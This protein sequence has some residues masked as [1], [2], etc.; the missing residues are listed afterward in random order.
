M[1]QAASRGSR[2]LATLVADHPTLKPS[3]VAKGISDIFL[4]ATLKLQSG[5][6]F[7]ATSFG[8]PLVNSP[9]SGEVVFT[10][11]V[12]GYPE[13][14]TDPSY[15]G[16]ILVFTQ[17]LVGNYGVPA[18]SRDEFGLL[19]H[20]E[21]EGIQVKGIIVNDYAAKYSHWNAIESLGQWC[22]RHNVPALSGVDTRQVVTLLRERGTT[23]GRITIGGDKGDAAAA[24]V[25]ESFYEDPSKTNL[26][27]EVSTKTHT[28]Y[29]YGGDVRIGLIDCG[30]KHNI[31]RH[32][33]KRGAQVHVVPWD[34]D[35]SSDNF[36]GIFISNGPG[37][38]LHATK[39]VE[40][41][42]KIMSAENNKAPTPVFGICM[43]NQIMGMAAGFPIYKLPY[44]NRGHNQPALNLVTGKCVITSQNHG[45]ALQDSAPVQDWLP[46]FRN[47]NDGSN[48]GIRH[49]SLPYS[50]VQFHPE[51]MGGPQDTEYLFQDFIDQVRHYKARRTGTIAAAADAPA[52]ASASVSI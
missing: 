31:I 11:S 8:A 51:A 44:G 41:L 40:T 47:A 18:P 27:A 14:M 38:P 32:L 9:I 37:N 24:A 3:A 28:I 12:V 4:P 26:I 36:D 35:L 29:N 48:E 43:G 23:L 42:R 19:K 45:Y 49:S 15:R 25:V 20:F 33:T 10:T 13:S 22:A 16:Q 39:T 50:A 7:K 52:R 2:S 46:Y 17:P 5:E 21:S 1:I 30:V 6:T 34:Y